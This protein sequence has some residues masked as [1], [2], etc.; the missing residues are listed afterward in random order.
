M[1]TLFTGEKPNS[2]VVFCGGVSGNKA[3]LKHLCELGGIDIVP[4][5]QS[6]LY[7]AVGAALC[8]IQDLENDPNNKEQ[9]VVFKKSLS[10][11]HLIFKEPVPKAYFFDKLHYVFRYFL[12]L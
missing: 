10:S 3:V 5:K 7:G 6:H 2:P 8:L 12:S 9:P 11:S 4:G 1:D